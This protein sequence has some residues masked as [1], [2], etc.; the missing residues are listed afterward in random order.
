M[1][2]RAFEEADEAAAAHAAAPR[3]ANGVTA[4][5]AAAGEAAHAPATKVA[6]GASSGHSV[7]AAQAQAAPI[8]SQLS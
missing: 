4:S 6:N 8:A 3:P 1:E 2:Q 5:A 7:T